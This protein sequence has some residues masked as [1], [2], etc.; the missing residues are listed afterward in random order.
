MGRAHWVEDNVLGGIGWLE[1]SVSL[2]PLDPFRYAMLG[3]KAFTRII[4]GDYA[5]GANLAD[6][7]ASAPGAHALIAAIAVV[8]HEMNGDRES[9][10]RWLASALSRKPDL[11]C[12][13]FFQAFP[14]DNARLRTEITR[15]LVAT[16]IP[17]EPAS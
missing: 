11:S 7:A 13:E 15:A 12:A 2:S 14:F 1:Q 4:E 10:A 3:V 16:G 9:A 17:E 5:Q 6:A 8:A